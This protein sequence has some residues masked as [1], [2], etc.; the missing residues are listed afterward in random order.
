MH[1]Q[2]CVPTG[3]SGPG[4]TH[5][6]ERHASPGSQPSPIVHGQPSEPIGHSLVVVSATDAVVSDPLVPPVVSVASVVTPVGDVVYG[7]GYGSTFPQ[8][9]TASSANARRTPEV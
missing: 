9:S 2:F 5:T 8:P 3:Q 1:G 6:S 4:S 7:Y